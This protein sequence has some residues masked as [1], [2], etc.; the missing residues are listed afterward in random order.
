MA[1]GDGAAASRNLTEH[2][3]SAAEKGLPRRGKVSTSHS[4]GFWFQIG[5]EAE[6]LGA[7]HE[8]SHL[9]IWNLAEAVGCR[10]ELVLIIPW[11]WL[12]RRPRGSSLVARRC[13]PS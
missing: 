12:R 8:S 6:G 13:S 1:D 2:S 3:A 4:N 5:G 9:T 11:P 7:G 10:I